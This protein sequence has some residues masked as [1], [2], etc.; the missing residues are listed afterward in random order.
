MEGSGCGLILRYYPGIRLEVLRKTTK[1][2][3]QDSRYTG[4]E[5][6]PET[7]KYEPGVL[8]T[9]PRRSVV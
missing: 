3:S 2:L 9:R 5:L 7:P 4:R 1:D 6:N 8:T